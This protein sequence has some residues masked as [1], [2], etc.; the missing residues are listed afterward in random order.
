[1]H[2][3]TMASRAKKNRQPRHQPLP[4]QQLI[5]LRGFSGPV[6]EGNIRVHLRDDLAHCWHNRPRIEG[7]AQFEKRAARGLINQRT[8]PLTRTR[9]SRVAHHSHD[10][11]AGAGWFLGGWAMSTESDAQ[12]VSLALE[13]F[14]ELLIHNHRG[15]RLGEFC[16]LVRCSKFE[17]GGVEDLPPE[18]MLACSTS[19]KNGSENEHPV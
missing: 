11:V 5:D 17:I 18:N 19:C 4:E 1:M 9:Q 8:D 2:A 7:G 3:S 13:F 10:F 15:R 6:E 16:T 14:D 12:R